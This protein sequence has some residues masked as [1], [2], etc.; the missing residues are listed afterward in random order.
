MVNSVFKELVYQILEKKNEPYFRWP[1]K[2][3]EDL[4]KRNQSLFCH[5]HQERGH[6]AEDCKT[7]RDHMG[8]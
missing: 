7:L 3:G 4:T 5:Y 1:N 8:Q 2:M 6:T